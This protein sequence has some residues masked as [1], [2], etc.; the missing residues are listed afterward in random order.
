MYYQKPHPH[1]TRKG[2]NQEREVNGPTLI[3]RHCARCSLAF[4]ARISPKRGYTQSYCTPCR[5]IINAAYKQQRDAKLALLRR[6]Y[7]ISR[8]LH[9]A[10][11]GRR[12]DPPP[13]RQR[14]A[15]HAD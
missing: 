6:A 13:S 5:G 15:R 3:R 10:T 12:A 7:R 2:T 14:D 1:S 4:D 9:A 8:G 11:V